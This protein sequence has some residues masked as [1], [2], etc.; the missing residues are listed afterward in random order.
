MSAYSLPLV[1]WRRVQAMTACSRS[2][3]GEASSWAQVVVNL[4]RLFAVVR[5]SSR[6]FVVVVTQLVTQSGV[7]AASTRRSAGTIA[8]RRDERLSS[9]AASLK[10]LIA[11]VYT[12][13][14]Q[15]GTNRESSK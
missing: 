3:D 4:L 12:K 2:Q 10:I 7:S 8:P 5:K 6:F 13:E 1:S 9:I 15:T 14:P 11:V